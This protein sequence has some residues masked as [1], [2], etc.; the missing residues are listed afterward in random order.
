MEFPADDVTGD[1]EPARAERAAVVLGA[2]RTQLERGWSQDAWHVVVR[3]GH[4][5]R[6]GRSWLAVDRSARVSS[7]LVGALFLAGWDYSDRSEDSAPAVD[8]L[9]HELQERRGLGRPEPLD[10][11]CAP[12]VRALRVLAP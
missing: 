1:R 5:Y 2:A 3:D 12:A 7:C 9:W 6:A 4:R 11:V 8:A 10:R